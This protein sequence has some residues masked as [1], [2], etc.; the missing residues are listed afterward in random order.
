MI[1]E[2]L[3][4]Q[5]AKEFNNHLQLSDNKRILFSGKFGVGKSSFLNYYFDSPE[6]KLKYEVF[7]IS[8]V[9]YSAASDDDIILYLKYDL[10]NLL[11][12][13]YPDVIDKTTVSMLTAGSV[14]FQYNFVQLLSS[15]LLVLP[16]FGSGWHKFYE[17][18]SEHK[19]EYER[20]KAHAESDLPIL[21]EF[22][23]E[24]EQKA[25]GIRQVAA[26]DDFLTRNL[27][28]VKKGKEAVLIIDD[29]DRI[30]PHHVFRI[31]NVFTAHFSGNKL[32][33]QFGFDKLILVCDEDNL[34]KMYT[35]FF[36][37]NVD[38]NGYV[39]KFYSHSIFRFN[40]R[41]AATQ[42]VEL[43]FRD[44]NISGSAT[45]KHMVEY[46]KNPLFE[47]M[48]NI[49][50]ELFKFGQI[51]LKTLESIRRSSIIV[52]E[53]EIVIS[54]YERF[55]NYSFMIVMVIDVLSKVFG[56]AERLKQCF[57]HAE[58]Q[59]A[60]LPEGREYH[61]GEIV[62]VLNLRQVHG[63][64]RIRSEPY[65]YRIPNSQHD[66]LY[67]AEYSRIRGSNAM[68]VSAVILEPNNLHGE[69]DFSLLG[70]L[71]EFLQVIGYF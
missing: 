28:A 59:G 7:N 8:P 65:A 40:N 27:T 2:S 9:D 36:G 14:Y 64:M 45:T 34:R 32:S 31:I 16:Y 46:Y 58:A 70:R 17:L 49:T 20:I 42:L 50:V 63:F 4:D 15:L 29:V 26:I 3:F 11:T 19:V 51:T 61:L 71:V 53:R 37:V 35:H 22:N 13:R 43:M 57:D 67:K 6:N 5:V 25:G 52:E 60:K 54:R 30:D 33:E 18:M 47:V 48:Q 66:L 21:K 69:S 68:A 41:M 38:Y 39:D 56:G 55:K 23:S 1:D 44:F 62:A 24:V 12:E 10:V